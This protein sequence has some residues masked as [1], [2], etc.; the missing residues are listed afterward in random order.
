MNNKKLRLK[1]I[2]IYDSQL[3]FSH[4]LRCHP[5]KIS[6]VI[7]G[8]EIL[9]PEVKEIWAHALNSDVKELFDDGTI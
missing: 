6:A 9:N 5:S 2:E 1:I 7:R 4:V 3:E 8:Q